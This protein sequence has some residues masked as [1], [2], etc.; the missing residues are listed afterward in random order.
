MIYA[1]PTNNSSSNISPQASSWPRVHRKKKRKRL[2]Y[3]NF[4]PPCRYCPSDN[5]MQILDDHRMFRPASSRRCTSL[6][7]PLS[8]IFSLPLNFSLLHSFF[9]CSFSFTLWRTV[10]FF[11][12]FTQ[13]LPSLFP[14]LYLCHECEVT[15]AAGPLRDNVC[16]GRA[17]SLSI[18]IRFASWNIYVLSSCTVNYSSVRKYV[19]FFT[20]SQQ[21]YASIGPPI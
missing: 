10:P 9:Y 13:L 11:L 12:H 15:T 4:F 16:N 5:V 17:I 21:F 6:S 14:S 18:Y 3:T 19:F 1:V 2:M 20:C 8:L 7:L